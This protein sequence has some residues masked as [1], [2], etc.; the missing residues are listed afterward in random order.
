MTPQAANT[1][2]SHYQVGAHGT[3][4]YDGLVDLPVVTQDGN[5]ATPTLT[6]AARQLARYMEEV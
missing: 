5:N 1:P 3:Q 2:T 4:L 6:E